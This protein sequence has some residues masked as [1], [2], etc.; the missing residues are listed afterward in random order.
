[1]SIGTSMSSR[2]EDMM[3]TIDLSCGDIESKSVAII[4]LRM[5]DKRSN[6]MMA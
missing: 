4:S 1:M 6:I 2:F 5:S 3:K